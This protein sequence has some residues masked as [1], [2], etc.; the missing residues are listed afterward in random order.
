[1]FSEL[2]AKF[3]FLKQTLEIPR[4]GKATGRKVLAVRKQV[5]DVGRELNPGHRSGSRVRAA[6]PQPDLDLTLRSDAITLKA[7]FRHVLLV[8]S[9]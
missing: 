9:V 6:G 1:M 2:A 4:A 8:A 5:L 3:S 7:F